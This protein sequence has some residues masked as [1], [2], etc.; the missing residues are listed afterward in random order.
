MVRAL[1]SI[2]AVVALIVACTAVDPW[3]S[4]SGDD[5]QDDVLKIVSSPVLPAARVVPRVPLAPVG[6]VIVERQPP[7]SRLTT[8]D[9]F[10]P[11]RARA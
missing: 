4:P 5:S 10:R 7:H 6:S 2:C 3:G 11:P 9:I 8:L 1:A